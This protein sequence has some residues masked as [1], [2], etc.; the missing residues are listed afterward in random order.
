MEN[1][2]NGWNGAIIPKAAGFTERRAF[3]CPEMWRIEP[4]MY[5]AGFP[6]PNAPGLGNKLGK[7]HVMFQ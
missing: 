6:A 7:P 4:Q 1:P 3:R 5:N 2:E